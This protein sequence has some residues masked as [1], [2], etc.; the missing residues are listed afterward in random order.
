MTFRTSIVAGLLAL[1]APAVAFASSS[2]LTQY[3]IEH[4]QTQLLSERGFTR[5]TSTRRE[6]APSPKPVD[7]AKE[8][9][10]HQN[11]MDTGAVRMTTGAMEGS[12]KQ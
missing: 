12:T 5:S 4:G 3:D 2:G 11:A 7:V 6:Q 1:A 8:Q 9:A 10:R